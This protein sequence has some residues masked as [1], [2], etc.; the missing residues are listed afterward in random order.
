MK[1][2]R[3]RNAARNIFFGSMLKIY[4][5]I[6]PFAM[7]TA[8]IYFMGVQYLGLNSLFTSI[9]Q[10]LNLAELGVGSAM[11][12]SMYKPIAEDDHVTICAL[13]RL[14]RIYYNVIG[15]VIA[16]AGLMIMP[17]IPKLI[18]S[19][20]PSDVNIY[21][22]YLMNLA[23][24]VLSYWLFAYKNSL[25]QAHQRIDVPSKIT[26]I[27][28]T[29]Q[30]GFQILVLIF[31]K[32]YYIYILVNLAAQFATNIVTAIAAS[33]LY[34]N[35]KPIGKLPKNDVQDIN[36]RIR[37]LFTSKIGSVVINASDTIVISAFLG[38]TA[39]AVYQNYYFILT[40]IIGIV[41][42]VFQ[43][44]TAG[45]GNSVILESKEKNFN[46]LK[47]FT[48]LISWVAGL[49]GCCLLCLFQPFMKI[50]VGEELMLEFSAVICF[51]AYYLIF[52]IN[53]L[54]NTYKDA[55]GIWHE[56]RF[57]PLVTAIVNVGLNLI[58]VQFIGIYGII[59]STV[60]SMLFVGMPWLL[61]NL[62]SVLFAKSQMG[63]YLKYL[64]TCTIVIVASC[65]VC[66][67]ICSFIDF[68][69][70]LTLVVRAALCCVIPNIF[71]LVVYRKT[72]EFK[73]CIPLVDRMTGHKLK[74][75]KRFLK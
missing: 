30:Y 61:R 19:D 32:N 70:W 29:V 37:D 25:F 56:D 5:I 35:Y 27:T 17:L 28:T 14:Y 72:P 20:L 69:P 50:W 22:L 62:F 23:L 38:L 60:L 65:A 46:D 54:L 75:E 49:C 67:F 57:R 55:A 74:L 71:Y 48:F 33:K 3:T 11:V 63:N 2:E 8:M 6:V 34:P 59:L 7:R 52:E 12:Y 36:H 31:L 41:A 43:S 42:I 26:L 24:T 15:G 4:Q 68:T 66:S 9:L 64:W 44:C 16:V 53:Q 39:L 47:K 51:V 45:I 73:Q 10:V 40:A 13:L 18:K 21:I 58:M 1:I